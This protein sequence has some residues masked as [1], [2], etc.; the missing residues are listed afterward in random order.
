VEPLLTAANVLYVCAYF[1]RSTLRLRLL[2]LGGTS[3]LIAYFMTLP[4]PLMQAVYWN[5]LYVVIN[6]VWIGRLLKAEDGSRK[7]G[8]PE[9]RRSSALSGG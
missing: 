4:Q 6:A 3:C 9:Y 2:S 8:G 7:A 5:L 1:V